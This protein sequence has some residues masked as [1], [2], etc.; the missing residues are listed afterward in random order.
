MTKLVSSKHNW[1]WMGGWAA[2]YLLA[3]ASMGAQTP[4]PRIHAQVTTS[5]MSILKGSL[6]P[7][8]QSRIDQGRM[9]ANTRFTGITMV[10][11]RS[12]AQQ[13]D[14]N[15]LLADQ[16]NP[17]SPLFHKWLTPE[18]FAARFGMAQSDLDK[19]TLWLQQQG[20]SVDYVA[21]SRTFI[22]FSG[23]VGQVEQAFQTQMHYYGVNGSRY[24]APSTVLSVPAA[25]VSTVHSIR[26][27]SNLR[28]RSMRISAGPALTLR[29]RPAF[30]SSQSGAVFFAP[31]DI[32][33]IYDVDPLASGGF[34]GTGQSIAVMGQSS[35]DLTD[36]SNFQSAAG[37]TQKA[38]T[39][40][41][42]PGTGSSVVYSGDESES[43]LDLEWS[44]AMA[45]GADIYFIYTG[46]SAN[47]SGVFDAMIYSIDERIGDILS[48]SYGAC[49]TALG[50]YDMETTLQQAA[51]QGQSV[52]AA[53][54][55]SGSTACAPFTSLT[56]TQQQALAVN[57]PASSP[58]VTAIGGTEIDG[59]NTAYTT[60][61]S[62]YWQAQGSTD[63]LSSALQYIP[64]VAWNDDDPT[65]GLS[66]TGGG[67]SSLFALPSYQ[68]TLLPSGNRRELPDISLFSSPNRVAYIYCTSDNSAWY[69]GTPPQASSCTGGTSFRDTVSGQ[70]YL[71]LAGGTSF[72]TPVFAGMLAVLNQAKGYTGGQGLINPTLYTL[73]TSGSAYSAAAGFHDITSGNNFCSAGATYCNGTAVTNYN[74]AVGYDPVTGLGSID[75]A[76]LA[77]SWPANSQSPP[78]IDTTTTISASN[79]TPDPNAN[80]TFTITVTSADG[81]TTPTGSVNLSIDE[82]VDTATGLLAGG[83]TATVT[84]AAGTTAGTATA[85]Y[86][87]S[88]ATPG[89][90]VVAA[91]FPGSSTLVASTGVVSVTVPGS[92][93]GGFTITATNLTVS[94]GSSGTS[95]VTVTPSGGYTGTVGFTVA[96]SNPNL[97]NTCYTATDATV[98]GTATAGATITFYTTSSDCTGAQVQTGGKGFVSGRLYK[99]ASSHPPASSPLSRTYEASFSFLAMLLAGIV[100][101]R[102]RKLRLVA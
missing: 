26:D 41:L 77:T 73:A 75:L 79:T 68:S 59:S 86:A 49:E 88:F 21:R 70:G 71:T 30:T 11:N 13:A 33:T 38:P 34:D 60:A 91:Q 85:T 69:N 82:G 1:L 31:G 92:A 19:V 50:G 78:L 16:Q 76:L 87:T 64:E 22:R 55:D 25:I 27:L 14:L 61:G 5:Q 96:T 58:N 62:A 15:Q 99:V 51:A 102:W 52:L 94:R 29:A 9:P 63:I 20:F 43:D 101:W 24:F 44:G 100:G 65:F 23:T 37:L 56:T 48:V 98:S 66:A 10:F 35:I 93:A 3:A 81:T 18:Q 39:L 53:S 46:S 57:Y 4:A 12:A 72:A 89:S 84:L 36:I 28:P 42:V 7:I 8:A 40:V 67:I 2:V 45:P 6:H 97:S 80:V 17:A 90:H 83:S 74:T 54:G 32:K 95:T 47:T